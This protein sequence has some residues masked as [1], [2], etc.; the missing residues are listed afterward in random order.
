MQNEEGGGKT[1]D[2]TQPFFF[3]S[4]E[5]SVLLFC[6]FVLL[7]EFCPAFLRGYCLLPSGSLALFS[8]PSALVHRKSQISH[9][10]LERGHL[11]TKC[12]DLS[13]AVDVVVLLIILI[14]FIF[15]L[16]D[17]LLLFLVLLPLVL[18]LLLTYQI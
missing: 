16:L 17:C 11:G 14:C 6:C 15:L 8:P 13:V 3:L 5:I 18:P 7:F 4:F 9:L 10:R 2:L 1:K 12:C